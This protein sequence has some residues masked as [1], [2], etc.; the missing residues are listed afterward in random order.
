MNDGPCEGFDRAIA[1]GLEPAAD[2]G[3]EPGPSRD[4]SRGGASG[5]TVGV[6]GPVFCTSARSGPGPSLTRVAGPAP[7]PG[8]SPGEPSAGP[9]PGGP[10]SGG[11]GSPTG[12][13]GWPSVL[14]TILP[15]LAT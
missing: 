14:R 9:A 7:L 3:A 15:S 5:G 1:S 6:E 10:V 2:P 13:P 11:A 12:A 4:G 8:L